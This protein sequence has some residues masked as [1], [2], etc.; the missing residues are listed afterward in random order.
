MMAARAFWIFPFAEV[1]THS[2]GC[3]QPTLIL[4]PCWLGDALRVLAFYV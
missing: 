4:M 2:F 1:G 3:K